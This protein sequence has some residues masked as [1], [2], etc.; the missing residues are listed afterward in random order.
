[1]KLIDTISDDEKIKLLT[2]KNRKKIVQLLMNEPSTLTMLGVK[3]GQSPAWIRHH[4]KRLEDAGLVE[5]CHTEL[6]NNVLEKFYKATSSVIQLHTLVLP[7]SKN[8]L[9]LISGSHDKALELLKDQLAAHFNIIIDTVG[10]LNGL[11]NLRQEICQISGSH[12]MDEGGEF[13]VSYVKHIFPDKPVQLVTL[14]TRTQGLIVARGNPK[15]IQSIDDLSR[16]DVRFLNRNPGSGT[17]VWLDN[18]I[19]KSG[20]LPEQICGYSNSVKT[21]DEVAWAITN[22]FADVGLGIQ[23]VAES[24]NLGFIPLFEE[25]FDF[26]SYMDNP[27]PIGPVFDH[28]NSSKFRTTINHLSG[29]NSNKSGEIVHY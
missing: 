5:L 13:N 29:Y 27:V 15:G 18:E 16:G 25:R 6:N 22:Q 24:E 28:I 12:L 1:M 23:C 14:V 10:S 9:I 2:D 11:I 20:I 26:A 21:H 3:M 17:R 8:P 7:E 4:I 19:K